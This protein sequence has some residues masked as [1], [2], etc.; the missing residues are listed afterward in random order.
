MTCTVTRT[1][2]FT[3]QW[4]FTT[5][6]WQ[7]AA[8]VVQAKRWCEDSTGY[9]RIT[10][11]GHLDRRHH[12]NG[13][14]VGQ[15]DLTAIAPRSRVIW[16]P[17]RRW[18]SVSSVSTASGRSDIQSGT[19][20]ESTGSASGNNKSS[21]SASR[22]RRNN[23]YLITRKKSVTGGTKTLCARRRRVTKIW[24]TERVRFYDV[25]PQSSFTSSIFLSRFQFNFFLFV[26]FFFFFY[27]YSLWTVNIRDIVFCVLPERKTAAAAAAADVRR[28]PR[29]WGVQR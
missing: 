21:W 26:F 19:I 10:V 16:I 3:Y 4:T 25:L 27:H 22:R 2:G 18:T 1:Q 28:C 17:L 12:I 6:R 13:A 5:N 7:R 20:T 15:F 14:T 8:N 24:K 11:F 9:C 23:K 29:E